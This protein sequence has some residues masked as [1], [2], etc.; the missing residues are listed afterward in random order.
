MHLK[1]LTLTL[2]LLFG[3]STTT[4]AAEPFDDSNIRDDV[5]L[6]TGIPSNNICYDQNEGC[7]PICDETCDDDGKCGCYRGCSTDHRK[8]VCGEDQHKQTEC[9]PSR[10]CCDGYVKKQKGKK[11]YQTICVSWATFR[12]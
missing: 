6:A 5:D 8:L 7:T 11:N 12:F 10:D 3:I 1:S 9:I 4:L 2:H